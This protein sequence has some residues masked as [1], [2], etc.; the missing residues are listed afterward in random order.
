[1]A[2]HIGLRLSDLTYFCFDSYPRMKYGTSRNWAA[3]CQLGPMVPIVGA[4]HV[5]FMRWRVAERCFGPIR[6]AAR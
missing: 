3:A 5:S 1:M 2:L 6:H 4:C